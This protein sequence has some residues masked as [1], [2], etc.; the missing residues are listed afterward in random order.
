MAKRAQARISFEEINSVDSIDELLEVYT[1]KG[2]VFSN[3]EQ[4]LEQLK[5][6]FRIEVERV[7]SEAMSGHIPTKLS[8][9]DVL[10]NNITYRIYGVQHPLNSVPKYKRLICEANNGSGNLIFENGFNYCF[11]LQRGIEMPDWSA[12]NIWDLLRLGFLVGI[13]LP[14][15]IA[16]TTLKMLIPQK[17]DDTSLKKLNIPLETY[18]FWLNDGLPAY[19]GIELQ[20]RRKNPS[21]TSIQKRSAYQAE[22]SRAWKKGED[23]RILVGAGHAAEIK[24]F[25]VNGVKDNSI[26]DLA[27]KHVGLL[28]KDPEKYRHFAKKAFLSGSI[29]MATPATVGYSS[30]FAYLLSKMH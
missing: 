27:H 18:S 10:I 19:V 25:L 28:E 23:K 6:D 29:F 13:H 16:D 14:L 9:L 5:S 2:H 15:I 8:S 20:E 30:V 4:F 3:E 7:K 17:T 21:Y 24:Y 1:K 22:F 26:V 11:D 12:N